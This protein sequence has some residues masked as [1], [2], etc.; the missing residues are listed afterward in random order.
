MVSWKVQENK[1]HEALKTFAGMSE[2]DAANEFGD[3]KVI[4]RWHDLVGFT[5]VAIVESNNPNALAAWLLTWN[6]TIDIQSV[7][8][9]DDNQARSVGRQ[10]LS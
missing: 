5:G 10:A 4:G 3:L 7:P 1:R 6:N 2:K 8:V 9:F